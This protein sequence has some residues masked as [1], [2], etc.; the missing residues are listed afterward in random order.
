MG[1]RANIHKTVS[2]YHIFVFVMIC[3][4]VMFV[5]SS[6]CASAK[7]SISQRQKEIVDKFNSQEDWMDKMQLLID[8]GTNYE[9][10]D[11]EYKNDSNL[12][13]GCS[14]RVWMLAVMKKGKLH[15]YGYTD[16]LVLNGFLVVLFNAFNDSSPKDIL[17]ASFEFVDQIQ[18][19]EHIS[20]TRS[21]DVNAIIAQ[22]L[23]I[24]KS[25]L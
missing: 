8:M 10:F 24:A 14:T 21:N 3:G 20:P 2:R 13:E 1:S 9:P 18:I 5:C 19:K 6:A 15:Y 7:K 17:Q 11:E 16:S 12:V 25:N 22:F 4:L 23:S